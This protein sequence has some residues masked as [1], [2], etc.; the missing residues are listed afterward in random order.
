MT[1]R[2]LLVEDAPVVLLVLKRMLANA[3]GIE[4][5]GTACNGKEALDLIPRLNP[6]VICTDL[7]MPEMDGWALTSE[8]MQRFPRPILVLSAS[9]Q[10]SDTENVFRV[11]DAGAVDVLAKPVGGVTVDREILERELLEKIRILAG[12]VVFS[13]HG[14]PVRARSTSRSTSVPSAPPTTDRSNQSPRPESRTQLTPN[15]TPK[16]SSPPPLHPTLN[17][18]TWGVP[19]P[20]APT[21]SPSS[22]AKPSNLPWGVPATQQ[23]PSRILAIGASTGGPQALST[24]LAALPAKFPVPILCTQHISQGFL[25]GLVRWL[26]ADCAVMVKI[27]QAGERAQSGHVY[28]APEAAH[29]TI[30][31]SGILRCTKGDLRDGHCPSVTVLFESVAQSFGSRATGILLTGMGRD[32]AAGLL[33]MARQGASTIAQDESS[34]VVFGMPKEAI[35]LNA[36]KFILP[37][38]QIASTVIQQ[39]TAVV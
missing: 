23:P 2:V 28:F 39:V 36:A 26:D 1:I 32:G 16:T 7:H 24:I 13:R 22:A 35:A 14:S 21:H 6:D 34:C 4:V 5:V 20:P 31:R 17:R 27:A 29:L 18:T 33:D 10:A 3:S 38:N 19:T 30:D 8:V 12:V 9:V 15:T 37:L 11:L 25:G